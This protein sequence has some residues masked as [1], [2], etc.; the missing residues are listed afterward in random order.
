MILCFGPVLQRTRVSRTPSPPE[1]PQSWVYEGTQL[2]E[3]RGSAQAAQNQE[4]NQNQ[5]GGIPR[6]WPGPP[7]EQN[8]APAGVGIQRNIRLDHCF[9]LQNLLGDL[10]HKTQNRQSEP[11]VLLDLEEPGG[12][13]RGVV[14]GTLPQVLREFQAGK[15]VGSLLLCPDGE[16]IQL[17]LYDGHTEMPELEQLALL[18]DITEEEQERAMG[19]DEDVDQCRSGQ[20]KPGGTKTLTAHRK[21]QNCSSGTKQTNGNLSIEVPGVAQPD[22]RPATRPCDKGRDQG[23]KQANG[24]TY[25]TSGQDKPGR[26]TGNRTHRDQKEGRRGRSLSDQPGSGEPPIGDQEKDEESDRQE[27]PETHNTPVSMVTV[28]TL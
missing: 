19:L 11:H 20:Q 8:P 5:R 2:P 6:D 12:P 25:L 10:T 26:R 3:E 4:E 13:T 14:K 28:E 1:E 16:V 9:Y 23:R 22:P 15:S 21:H 17:S 24:E 7:M 18:D 27:D